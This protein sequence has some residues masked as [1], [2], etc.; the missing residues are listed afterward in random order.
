VTTCAELAV[1]TEHLKLVACSLDAA[2]ASLRGASHVARLLGVEVPPT[3]PPRDL[4]DALAYHARELAEDGAHLGWG[5]WLVLAGEAT[6]LAGSVGF[7]GRPDHN[8]CVEIGYGIEPPFRGHGYATEA[9]AALVRWGFDHGVRRILAE[10]HGDNRPSIR[11]LEKTG[12]RR[13]G[14]RGRMLWWELCAPS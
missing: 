11:V 2:R 10:C 12:M 14:E 3:W 1:R 4:V 6:G 8:G 7:K 13:I 5:V 9:V